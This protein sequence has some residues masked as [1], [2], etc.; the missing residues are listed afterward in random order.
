V[1]NGFHEGPG[2]GGNLTLAPLLRRT[3][4]WLLPQPAVPELVSY[5]PSPN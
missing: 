2:S 1:L 5:L 3:F 4:D